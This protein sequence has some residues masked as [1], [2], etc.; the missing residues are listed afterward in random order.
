MEFLKLAIDG[1]CGLVHFNYKVLEQLRYFVNRVESQKS[2]RVVKQPFGTLGVMI[3]CLVPG[4]RAD[5]QPPLGPDLGVTDVFEGK[6]QA[7]VGIPFLEP[8][9][10]RD[11]NVEFVE[12]GVKSGN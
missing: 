6:F 1:L 8:D 11:T 12:F 4:H 7:V 10:A 5:C 2:R 9:P 3:G